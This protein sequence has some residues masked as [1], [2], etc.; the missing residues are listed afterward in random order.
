[1]SLCVIEWV[2]NKLDVTGTH[3][4][5]CWQAWRGEQEPQQGVGEHGRPQAQQRERLEEEREEGRE[6]RQAQRQVQLGLGQR[7]R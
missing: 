6:L 5:L 2:A 4:R 3:Q 1:M 7:G